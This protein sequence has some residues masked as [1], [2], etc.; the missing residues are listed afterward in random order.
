MTG[1]FLANRH[2]AAVIEAGFALCA[3][4]RAFA[5]VRKGLI[6]ATPFRGLTMLLEPADA[7]E[8]FEE[9]FDAAEPPRFSFEPL[10]RI[11]DDDDPPEYVPRLR[12]WRLA[13]ADSEL[14]AARSAIADRLRAISATAHDDWPRYANEAEDNYA[15]ALRAFDAAQGGGAD[16]EHHPASIALLEALEVARKEVTR[17]LPAA[18]AAADAASAFAYADAADREARFSAFVAATEMARREAIA[19][20]QV[21]DAADGSSSADIDPREESAEN[22][23]L[24]SA[25]LE[26]VNQSLREIRFAA[27]VV[28]C[29]G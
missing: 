15:E 11:E 4:S 24:R 23:R 12:N 3:R 9:A 22:D 2:R 10:V 27:Y 26:L 19:A 29:L 18:C 6:V 25:L 13:D 16:L 17:S 20:E 7:D 14:K 21:C 1:K 8:L 5:P 28:K